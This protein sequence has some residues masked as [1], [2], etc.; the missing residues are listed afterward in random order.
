MNSISTKYKLLLKHYSCSYIAKSF[1]RNVITLSILM[2]CDDRWCMCCN[3]SLVNGVRMRVKHKCWQTTSRQEQ[4][5]NGIVRCKYSHSHIW[6]KCNF[7]LCLCLFCPR[8]W[9][10]FHWNNKRNYI[11][12]NKHM[13]S[14]IPSFSDHQFNLLTENN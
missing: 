5:F 4:H 7:E 1:S 13:I 3:C 6:P 11:K 9:K 8:S 12:F 14:S 2:K 10:S